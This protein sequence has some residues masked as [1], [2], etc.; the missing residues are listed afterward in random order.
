M[1]DF[2]Q[3]QKLRDYANI[4]FEEAKKALEETNGDLL[5]AVIKL[6][7][8]NKIH[9]PEAAGYYSSQSEGRSE[10]DSAKFQ[11]RHNSHH[12]GQ[13]FREIVTAFLRWCGGII[14]KGNINSFEVLQ[15]DSRIITLPV[16]VLVV[17][18]LFAFWIVIPLLIL[19]LFFGCR[20]RFSGPDLDKP[21]VNQ[22]MEKVSQAT[23]RAVDTVVNAVEHMTRDGDKDKGETNGAHS[24]H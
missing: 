21:A 22:A 17:L 14:H 24:D 1:V 9:R 3:V 16:T 10:E 11:S 19:G 15:D 20:Y 13:S 2:E 7:K 18:L 23:A 8:E 6:E 5:E 4:T 12:K